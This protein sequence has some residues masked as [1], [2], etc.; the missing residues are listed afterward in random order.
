M[1]ESQWFATTVRQLFGNTNPAIPV[2][3]VWS[4]QHPVLYTLIW[5]V[6]ILLVFV[7]LSISQYRRASA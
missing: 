7:P 3:E 6:I 1:L 4:M 5:V 2:P